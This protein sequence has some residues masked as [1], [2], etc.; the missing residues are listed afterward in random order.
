MSAA[1]G[2]G[3]STPGG[4]E[5]GDEPRARDS[6]W[7][8]SRWAI[9]LA[10]VALLVLA[11]VITGPPGDT[12]PL[13]PD[14]T[15]RAGLRGVRD[16]LASVGVASEVSLDPP[17]DRSTRVFVPLDQ[18]GTQRREAFLDWV[19]E[20]GTLVVADPR[21]LLHDLAPTGAGFAGVF[22][23]TP[24]R[25][26]CDL[27]A[28]A[29]VGEVVHGGW[30]DLEVAEGAT[31]CFPGG[32][33]EAWLVVLDEGEGTI[34]ALGSAEP[35]TN[36]QLDRGDNAVLAAALLGPAPGAA[37]VIVPRAP[38]GEGD[39]ALLDLVPVRV[40][41][42]LAVLLLALVL[43]VVWRGRRLGLPVPERLPP[44]VPA[45]ELARSVA[46]LLQRARSRP[47]AA[48]LLR[49]HARQEVADR[50]G[51]T[52]ASVPEELVE[53]A[54][55][56]TGVP[57]EVARTALLDAPVGDD[58]ALVEVARAAA[59]LRAALSGG[60]AAPTSPRRTNPGTDHP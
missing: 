25:T 36:G 6:R 44:V 43:G 39:V 7:R 41:R 45:A 40:W 48:A 31:G 33:D 23:A 51:A 55:A 19:R 15:D 21:S 17:R 24:R 38:V 57:P 54:V 5:A 56:R 59:T 46:G 35:F 11:A 42:G 32:P 22:G 27:P 26:G 50:L 60:R 2:P 14:G 29:E 28:L 52:R 58:E 18:L 9:A 30:V 3:Q 12:E 34:V 4:R 49:A 16:L 37:L 10:M 20:G 53:L 47:G 1:G 13:D 8:P